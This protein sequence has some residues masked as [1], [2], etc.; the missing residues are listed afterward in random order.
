MIIMFG[1]IEHKTLQDLA[2]H[3][4]EKLTLLREN[5]FDVSYEEELYFN[6]KYA[7][8]LLE[9]FKS[10][11]IDLTRARLELI[12][13]KIRAQEVEGLPED[14]GP[15]INFGEDKVS[16]ESKENLR[17]ESPSQDFSEAPPCEPKSLENPF[18]SLKL[19]EDPVDI[20]QLGPPLDF[21]PQKIRTLSPPLT[22][23]SFLNLG[24]GE[25]FV[26]NLP[27]QSLENVENCF[28][29]KL[30][31]T[32]DSIVVVENKDSHTVSSSS[33]LIMEKLKFKPTFGQN[34]FDAPVCS[35]EEEEMLGEIDKVE[36][37]NEFDDTDDNDPV[38][39]FS[40]SI[41]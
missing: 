36:A 10:T 16:A 12:K 25:D 20:N 1:T 6:I 17:A 21:G 8:N 22:E 3:F 9:T 32:E 41:L 26:E 13:I 28:N 5:N 30:A 35:K 2:K 40:C 39:P 11:H 23:D 37:P 14:F 19:E 24:T 18:L 15:T 27:L 34:S 38:P 33:G 29:A 4:S 7:L 31:E